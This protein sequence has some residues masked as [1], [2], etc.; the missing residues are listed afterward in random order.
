MLAASLLVSS[1]GWTG[2]P[3]SVTHGTDGDFAPKRV[4]SGDVV[5]AT[6]RCAEGFTLV[7]RCERRSPVIPSAAHRAGPRLATVR[8]SA[9][10]GA[11]VALALTGKSPAASAIADPASFQPVAPVRLELTRRLRRG[12]LNPLRLPFRQG[13]L[14]F[15][16]PSFCPP[17]RHLASSGTVNGGL[18]VVLGAAAGGLALYLQ[19]LSRVAAAQ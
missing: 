7:R 10:L 19:N 18:G 3:S 6:L 2:P 11:R 4:G 13:A 9:V 15:I 17:C 5:R 16:A 8:A 1:L 12:I 14:C